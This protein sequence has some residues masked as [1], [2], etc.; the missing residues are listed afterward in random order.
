MEET[1][2]QAKEYSRQRIRLAVYQLLLTL[3]FLTV[4][5][6]SGISIFLK[7]LA[8][9]LSQNF[10]IQ[11]GL[12]LVIFSIVYYLLFVGLDFYGGFLLE[13]KFSLSTQT[14]LYWLKQ[15]VKK[16]LMSLA[17]F[18]TAGEALY[19]FLRH[20]PNNWWLLATTGWFL[21]TVVLGKIAPVLIIP[22]FYKCNPLDNNVLKER[23]LNLCKTCGVGIKQVYEIQ[24]SKE[25][26]KANAAVAGLGKSRR[27]LLAD[28]L[29]DNYSDDE[30]EATFAHELGHVCLHHVCKILT[31]GA[32]ISLASFYL[33]YVLFKISLGIFGFNQ[34]YDIA[35]FC[36][37][38]LILMLIGLLFIPVQNSFLRYLEKQADMFALGH[39]GNSHSFV[40]AIT[41]LGNQNLDDPSPSKVVKILFHTHPS[42]SERVLYASKKNEKDT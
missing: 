15:S 26:R 3:A 5:L 40:S 42:I 18:L 1:S 35:A 21:L 24:L 10:Y 9:S 29:L 38:A 4:M 23:L 36:L 7:D 2:V 20:F 11:V 41:K 8:V 31:F 16:W 37:L 19:V 39:I 25:T 14:I 17:V 13:R 27:I 28:T 32:V 33:A 12:Y 30:I 34:I 22:L 6:F